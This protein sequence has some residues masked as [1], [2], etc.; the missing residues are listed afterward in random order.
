MCTWSQACLHPQAFVGAPGSFHMAARL[1][2]PPVVSRW[3]VGLGLP[4]P[5]PPS[6]LV[7]GAPSTALPVASPQ[8]LEAPPV[9]APGVFRPPGWARRSQSPVLGSSVPLV[10]L[11]TD[12]ASC[13]P[14]PPE[15]PGPVLGQSVSARLRQGGEACP[16]VGRHEEDG[17]KTGQLWGPDPGPGSGSD[18]S[19]GLLACSRPKAGGGGGFQGVP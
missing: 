18:P 19:S 7:L 14:W 1:R 2:V 5:A 16:G 9:L 12:T 17:G 3:S 13:C 6:L 8:L 15:T 11:D 10:A 4:S